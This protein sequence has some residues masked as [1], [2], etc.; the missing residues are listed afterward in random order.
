VTIA[1]DA[2]Y[3]LD[4]VPTG[5]AVYSANL[6]RALAASEPDER[7]LL[8][9][10]ANRFFRSL[11]KGLPGPNCSRR[12]LED[13]ACF[14]FRSGV[15]VFHGLNQRLPRSRFRRRVTT[16]H[17]LFVMTGD[18]STREFRSR[19]GNLA[20]EAAAQSDYIIAVSEHTA[21]QVS[22]WLKFPRGLISVVHHG[23]HP[24]PRFSAQEID[25]FRRKHR[26]EEPFVLHVGAL[27]KRKN[28][29]RLVEAF[30]GLGPPYRLVLAGSDGYGAN[31]I[32]YRI[33]QSP[34]AAW[35]RRF[36][37]VD[38]RT[39][40]LLYRTASVLAFPSLEEGFGLPV[41]EAMSAELPVVISDRGALPEVAGDAAIM[42]D[43]EDPQDL[44][45]TLREVL[46]D[47]ALR[48]QLT[49][50]GLR[51]CDEFSWVKAAHETYRVYQQLS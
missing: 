31:T 43:P 38:E 45:N 50:A 42:A 18:Y 7:F 26:L 51:R 19:F 6:I 20:R 10:R 44:R 12:L 22:E 40:A 14:T 27:Q 21:Q 33:G 30:E 48:E 35:I 15:S 47:D 34:V 39:L 4:R 5:V 23:V 28:I 11:R 9:Y 16:F 24:V 49:R 41:L 36:G 3:S 46:E 17:D 13:F 1:L 32:L 8:C 25:A 37:Y 29:Q 2:S